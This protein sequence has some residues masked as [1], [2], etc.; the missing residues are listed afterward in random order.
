M[1]DFRN[2]HTHVRQ[3]AGG[4]GTTLFVADRTRSVT[5]V[6]AGETDKTRTDS[7]IRQVRFDELCRTTIFDYLHYAFRAPNE[8][9]IRRLAEI[10]RLTFRAAFPGSHVVHYT[11]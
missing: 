7:D 5:D 1:I 3:P 2:G 10:V 9:R 11:F 8:N 6:Y 4:G